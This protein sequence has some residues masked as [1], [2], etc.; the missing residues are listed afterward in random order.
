MIQQEYTHYGENKNCA[1]QIT[2]IFQEQKNSVGR[3]IQY[4]PDPTLSFRAQ[5][6]SGVLRVY[7]V[8]TVY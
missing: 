6:R 8:L 1:Q 3:P 2:E 7:A 5:R 4:N